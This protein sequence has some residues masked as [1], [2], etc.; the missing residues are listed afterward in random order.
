M[1]PKGLLGPPLQE[2]PVLREGFHIS[3]GQMAP[4]GCCYLQSQLGYAGRFCQWGEK[5]KDPVST[6]WMP[7]TSAAYPFYR[8]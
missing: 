8:T 6:P 5:L 1:A 3:C 2:A 7:W 4:T